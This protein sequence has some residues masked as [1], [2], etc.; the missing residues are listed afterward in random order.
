MKIPPGKMTVKEFNAWLKK[1][2]DERYRLEDG[3]TFCKTCGTKTELVVCFVSVHVQEFGDL[4]AGGGDV[5]RVALDFCP[6]CEQVP[7]E[8]VTSCVHV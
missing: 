7:T 4:C 6:R 2:R 1:E 5:K 8:M 3:R